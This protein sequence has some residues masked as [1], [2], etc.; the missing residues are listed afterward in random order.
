M[1][2]FGN[3]CQRKV[4]LRDAFLFLLCMSSYN[5]RKYALVLQYIVDFD[6][7]RALQV[8]QQPNS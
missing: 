5:G 7:H 6:S 2:W 8:L 3:F 1:E 4:S